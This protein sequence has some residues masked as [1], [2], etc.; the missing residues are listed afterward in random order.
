VIDRG[1]LGAFYM[2]NFIIAKF[3]H[4]EVLSRRIFITVFH[5][6]IFTEG[7]EFTALRQEDTELRR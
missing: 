5:R 4:S 6:G 2:R 3:Y 1:D 7:I